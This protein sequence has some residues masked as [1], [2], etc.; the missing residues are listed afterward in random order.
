[1]FLMRK[2]GVLRWFRLG[3]WSWEVDFTE[4]VFHGIS[5]FAVAPVFGEAISF[6]LL[7]GERLVYCKCYFYTGIPMYFDKTLLK[8][9][10]PYAKRILGANEAVT[11]ARYNFRVF[12]IS[13]RPSSALLIKKTIIK[14]S[15]SNVQP[16]KFLTTFQMAICRRFMVIHFCPSIK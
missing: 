11:Y 2:G 14:K 13:W 6:S 1:M 7:S 9:R 5:V 8:S 4:L 3:S 12:S 15:S 16:W 10:Y